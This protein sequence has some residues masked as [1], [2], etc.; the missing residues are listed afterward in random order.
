MK[1]VNIFENSINTLNS[2]FNIKENNI[3]SNNTTFYANAAEQFI[4]N[5][6]YPELYNIYNIKYKKDN[7]K[8]L[9]KQKEINEKLTIDEIIKKIGLKQKLKGNDKIPFKRVIDIINKINFEKSL[10]KKYEIMTQASLEIRNCVLDNTNCKYEL[11]SMDDELPIVIYI[12]T[13]LKV[14]NLYAELYMIE[15][16]IKC[17]LRDRLAENKTVTNL[18]SSILYISNSWDN[19]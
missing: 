2:T 14:N 17:S 7:E 10:K 8:Y 13:Q 5:K 11:D 12:T 4:L 9:T 18:M 15:D 16:Y 1:I 6:I 3:K 19:E